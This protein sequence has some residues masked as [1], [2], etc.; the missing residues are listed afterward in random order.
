MADEQRLVPRHPQ[1]IR[2]RDIRGTPDLCERVSLVP[3]LS[4]SCF[5]RFVA[6]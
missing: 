4:W 2:R 3:R 6:Q 5:D 1:L